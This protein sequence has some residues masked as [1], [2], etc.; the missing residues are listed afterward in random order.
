MGISCCRFTADLQLL[1]DPKP[2]GI[3]LKKQI[4]KAS[5]KSFLYGMRSAE[6]EH[7]EMG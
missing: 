1:V 6:F 7:S 3:D 2:Q 5:A 4:T